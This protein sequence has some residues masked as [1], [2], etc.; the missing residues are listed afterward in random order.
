[1]KK[2]TLA[3]FFCLLIP[4]SLEAK[5]KVIQLQYKPNEKVKVQ[6]R[7]VPSVKI[8]IEEVR[9]ARPHPREIGEN[10][11]EKDQKVLIATSD[12]GGARQFVRSALNKEFR[13]KGFS[14]EDGSG[15]AQKII[16]GTLMKFWT[17]ETNRY[18]SQA[19]LRIEV[20][21][22]TGAVYFNKT[23]SGTGK[24]FGRSLNEQ[25]YYESSSDA[26]ANIVDGLFS[27]SEFLKALAEKPRTGR[28]EEK[29]IG[30]AT[31]SQPLPAGTTK[32]KGRGRKQAA[33][34]P[35]TPGPPPPPGSIPPGPAFGPK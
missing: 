5:E 14:V 28:V 19:Q 13:D 22:K 35:A 27:D 17:I 1:L 8:Y 31:V 11:E 16:G 18:N 23:Y 15:Q 2:F 32:P 6:P 33:P 34:R 20:K 3:V 12:G 24:N 4:F 21:D 25:N 30:P 7:N 26:L 29:A 9:D 10:Q